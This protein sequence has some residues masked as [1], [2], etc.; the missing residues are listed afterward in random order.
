M[1][2]RKSLPTIIIGLS[3]VLTLL[4][5]VQA[6]QGLEL[7]DFDLF[8][9]YLSNAEDSKVTPGAT[10]TPTSTGTATAT[11][12]PT[13]TPT[14]TATPTATST[15][16]PTATS[17][18]EIVIIE[19]V[20]DPPSV[21]ANNPVNFTATTK[22]GTG[23]PLYD[24][25]L[26]VSIEINGRSA[27]HYPLIPLADHGDGTY[28]G[29]FST[30]GTGRFTA[31]TVV[32]D[33][34]VEDKWT[35]SSDTSDF[36][37][38]PM[39]V[40]SLDMT[41]WGPHNALRPWEVQIVSRDIYSNPVPVAAPDRAETVCASPDLTIE[42]GLVYDD[43]D[44]PEWVE[45][46]D[47][48]GTEYTDGTVDC[49]QDPGVEGTAEVVYPPAWVQMISEDG[50]YGDSFPA[51]SFFD[52][53]FEVPAVP[54]PV[55]PEGW[56]MISGTLSIELGDSGITFSGCEETS[57]DFN[58]LVC[59]DTNPLTETFDLHFVV[60]YSTTV[61]M[62]AYSEPFKAR[63]DTPAEVTETF[64]GAIKLVSFDLITLGGIPIVY[65]PTGFLDLWFWSL[66]L[67]PTKT[68]NMHIYVV[69]GSATEAQAKADAQ[70]AENGFNLNALFCICPFFIDFNVTV[71]TIPKSDWEKIDE[72]GDG[73]DRYDKN[74][75]GD[76]DDKGENDDLQ[77]AKDKGYYDSKAKTEN[78]YYV[79]KI[80]NTSGGSG[81]VMGMCFGPGG[82]VAVN[83][84]VDSDGLTLM[85]EKV[86][87][88]DNRKDGDFDVKDSPD[89]PKNK[90]GAKNPGNIMNY[91]KTGPWL[92]PIQCGFLDP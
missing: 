52:V 73:L 8:L 75:D 19:L 26:E 9:P 61:G 72:D 43:P 64:V 89:D 74:G 6:V 45:R 44:Y 67:K 50:Y 58:V 41:N 17:T 76:Y 31:G 91:D 46:V 57:D 32:F 62:T 68:L 25:D 88:L 23:T 37:V 79:P 39:Q 86:H 60:E 24:P 36:T 20:A 82:Q 78:V 16:T 1:K 30:H 85:H 2:L 22:D 84:S 90:Q 65:D 70:Q 48:M 33:N 10:A 42:A 49:T 35:M 13:T 3:L 12:T 11:P 4:F 54:T 38:T 55:A 77:N 63:F 47:V 87:E 83:N 34:A 80:R 27:G 40:S 56:G 53:M 15:A 66:Y 69:E 29:S 81:T 7:G 71:E 59:E 28:T 92:T 5:T 18:P 14:S 51:E 21:Q